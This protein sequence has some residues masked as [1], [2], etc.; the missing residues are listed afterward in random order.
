MPRPVRPL[1]I[2]I[3]TAGGLDSA[4]Y[5]ALGAQVVSLEAQVGSQPFVRAQANPLATNCTKGRLPQHLR[6][7]KLRLVNAKISTGAPQVV[8]TC[9]RGPGQGLFLGSSHALDFERAGELELPRYDFDRTRHT[10]PPNPL[11]YENRVYVP[12][13]SCADLISSYGI[14][15]YMKVDVEAKCAAS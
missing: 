13:T 12:T 10:L 2:D 15:F 9:W 5:L 7:R 11:R 1:I 4:L 14:P 3:G 8:S 6:T